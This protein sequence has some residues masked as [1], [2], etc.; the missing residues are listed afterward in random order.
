M[1]CTC[2]LSF[3]VKGGCLCGEIQYEYHG[4]LSE[5]VICHCNQC[6]KAQ[7]T[8]F[9]VNSPIK[10]DLFKITQGKSRLQAYSSSEKKQRVF[11]S[12]CGSPVFSKHQDNPAMI[13][14][15]TGTITSGLDREPDYQQYVDSKANWL[16]LNPDIPVFRRA[17]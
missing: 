10:A 11:C 7:G 1:G 16:E 14:I 2:Y 4:S 8:V 15:R 3:M 9:A 5:L 17:K 13:R 6:K 12:R